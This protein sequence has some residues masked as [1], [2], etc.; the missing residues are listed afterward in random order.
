[1]P[2]INTLFLWLVIIPLLVIGCTTEAEE[3][4]NSSIVFGLTLGASGFDPHIHQ[5]SELG[6]VLRQVYDTLVYRDPNTREFVPGLATNWTISSD[7]QSYT[8][9][10]RQDV[11]F[12]DGT[13]FNAAAVAANLDRIT[14][15]ET[16]SQRAVYMLGPYVGYEIIDSHTI[17]INL[18]EPYS[19]LLDSLSQVFLGIASPTALA[20]YS[21]NRY[22]FHQVGT[23]P[24][25]FVEYTPGD[26]IVL[27]RSQDYAWGPDF[28][29]APD[30]RVADEIV[31]R[32]F[33][34]SAT[35]ALALESGEAHIMG[36]LLPS[37]ARALTGHGQI[38]LL[39]TPIPGQPLQFM[40]NTQRYP[41]DNL[42]VRQALLYATNRSVI[43]D[44]V[45]QG[46]SPIAWGPLSAS[47][48]YYSQEVVGLYSYNPQQARALLNS[49][50]YQDTDN[51]GYLNGAD[52]EELEVVVIVPSWGLVP[53]TALLLQD[54][55]R[56]VGIRA[57]LQPVPGFN[58]LQERVSSGEYNLVAFNSFG[59]DPSLL[60]EFFLSDGINNYSRYSN[61][62]LDSALRAAAREISPGVRR[63]LY[64]QIQ[65]FIME[66]ALIL[67]IRDYV[68][69]NAT[70]ATI[71]GLQF[72][73]YGWF[74]LLHNTVIVEG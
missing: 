50:G 11:T 31:F 65:R 29:N 7:N 46:Y 26:K 30:G 63:G 32:F 47:T 14:N 40:L 24:Y 68:N 4:S 17:R 15:P 41:T 54:Q 13:P 21:N 1:M 38:Q 48:I 35:R 23:G 49:I 16:V 20:E 27:R 59:L 58:A 66:Q 8:F 9:T 33:T 5:S 42:A 64:A 67:P 6:I 57:V 18:S 44:T 19:A 10:L 72:D 71:N 39:P 70:S 52:G 55:W 45:F 37:D 3:S 62:N 34:D 60:N 51:S 61:Q 12:H 73:P 28:Y 56:E 43:V 74:P 2:S 25:R 22:Q 69:L 36:E 53:E